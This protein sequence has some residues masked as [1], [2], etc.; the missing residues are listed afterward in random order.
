MRY[1]SR[2]SRAALAVAVVGCLPGASASATDNIA[3]AQITISMDTAR[4]ITATMPGADSTPGAWTCGTSDVGS[5][6][7]VSCAPAVAATWSCQRA[8]L[9]ASY[10]GASTDT[11]DAASRCGHTAAT[12]HPQQLPYATGYCEDSASGGTLPDFVCEANYAGIIASV[13]WTVV[14]RTY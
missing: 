2:A 14:C 8:Y 11:L 9:L 7:T 13:G 6:Y 10:T 1:L 5:V 3:R 12:C 4:H